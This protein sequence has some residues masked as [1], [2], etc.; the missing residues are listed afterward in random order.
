MFD[1]IAEYPRKFTATYKQ[2]GN[3]YRGRFYVDGERVSE[4]VFNSALNARIKHDSGYTRDSK[5]IRCGYRIT[6]TRG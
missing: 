2:W 6:W 5:D 1:A 4:W 3:L